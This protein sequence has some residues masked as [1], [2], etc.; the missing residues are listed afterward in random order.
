M[1]RIA[2]LTPK[3]HTIITPVAMKKKRKKDRAIS[4][5]ALHFT[6]IKITGDEILI[7]LQ[8]KLARLLPQAPCNKDTF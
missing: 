6:D 5:H 8:S 2:N 3:L 4:E 1:L 7:G